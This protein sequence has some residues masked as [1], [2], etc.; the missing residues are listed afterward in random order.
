MFSIKTFKNGEVIA[1]CGDPTPVFIVI[2]SGTACIWSHP[3]PIELVLGIAS[4]SVIKVPSSPHYPTALPFKKES[5]NEERSSNEGSNKNDA[6]NSQRMQ[7]FTGSF[8][9]LEN[10]EVMIKYAAF[11]KKKK[12]YVLKI[13]KI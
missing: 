11:K 3:N 13:N 4:P 12:P 1:Q 5:S 7:A 6:M 10:F 2:K 9:T 8:R